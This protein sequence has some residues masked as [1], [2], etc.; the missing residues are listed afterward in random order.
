MGI[1][2]DAGL[3]ASPKQAT[4]V[5]IVA[6]SGDLVWSFVMAATIGRA[7]R[8]VVGP[9]NELRLRLGAYERLAPGPT[10]PISYAITTA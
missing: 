10:R 7:D 4:N 6:E 1:L 9:G 3:A 5:A 2:A 8:P